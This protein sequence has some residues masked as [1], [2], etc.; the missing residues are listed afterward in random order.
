MN[1]ERVS[2]HWIKLCD[3]TYAYVSEVFRGKQVHDSLTR[4][5][6]ILQYSS[7]AAFI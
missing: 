6:V 2:L 3:R 1:V 4:N 5:H 7:G